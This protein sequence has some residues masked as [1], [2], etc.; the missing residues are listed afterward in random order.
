MWR[1]VSSP[2]R[3]ERPADPAV[4]DHPR[5]Q[6]RGAP[7]RRRARDRTPTILVRGPI[8][9]RCPR[10][11]GRA[12]PG[13]PG[14]RRRLAT[15]RAASR[16]ADRTGPTSERCSCVVKGRAPWGWVLGRPCGPGLAR[17]SA[18]VRRRVRWSDPT[19]DASPSSTAPP[20]SDRRSG[21]PYAESLAPARGDGP[22]RQDCRHVRR[23]GHRPNT[24]V[25]PRRQPWGSNWLNVNTAPCGS[26]TAAAFVHGESIGPERPVAPSRRA[27][28]T[29]S[30]RS[31]TANVRCQLG[32]S[33]PCSGASHATASANPGGASM[34]D[35]R[36]W[37]SGSMVHASGRRNRD[38]ATWLPLG[39]RR[40]RA[41]GPPNRT[42]RRRT[43][44]P[45]R[46]HRCAGR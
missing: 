45:G 30:S 17:C 2:A 35:C 5:W 37:I 34:P 40:S 25:V 20:S 36:A 7:C 32:S 10:F 28:A 18:S 21:T 44:W 23:L 31:A 22:D 24:A 29:L 19:T 12:E 38:G 27:V 41:R 13:A 16:A 1:C 43:T 6:A 33:S 8:R 26:L 11:V 4:Q 14:R 42:R 9:E 15:S 39:R 46:R 3:A